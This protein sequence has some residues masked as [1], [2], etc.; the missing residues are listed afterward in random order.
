ML[1]TAIFS[2]LLALAPSAFAKPFPMP[3]SDL[4]AAVTDTLGEAGNYKIIA[5]D[6]E[7]MKASFLVV[8]ALYP[9]S[10]VLSLKPK[11]N[12]CELQIKMGFTGNDNDDWALWRRVNRAVAKQKEAK[13]SRPAPSTEKA[14]S[15]S[16]AATH[17]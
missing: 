2:L 11:G 1:R 8:G 7:Q 17:N 15:A 6:D 10:N 5:I 14:E 13:E 12:G 9:A 3:C 4:W 16:G